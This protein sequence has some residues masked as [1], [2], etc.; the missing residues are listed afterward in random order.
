MGMF[1][2]FKMPQNQQFQYRPRFW[3]QEKDELE[4]RMKKIDRPEDVTTDEIKDSISTTFRNRGGGANPKY[5]N[6]QVMQSNKILI[7]TILILAIFTYFI[8]S[9]NMD[10]LQKLVN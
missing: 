10:F 1:R 9:S 5:R 2:I 6:Q 7:L 8:L 4:K 3:D